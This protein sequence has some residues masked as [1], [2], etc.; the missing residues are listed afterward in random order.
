MPN[1]KPGF[2]VFRA[3]F[4]AGL[5][6]S[7][8][9]VVVDGGTSSA[10]SAGVPNSVLA[11]GSAAGVVGDTA[12][13]VGPIAAIAAPS[14]GNGYWVTSSTGQVTS[15]G[16]AVNYGSLS[17][18]LQ[19]P[20]VGMASTPDGSGYW[21]V[22]SD[23]GIFTFGD[24]GFFGS[25]GAIRLNEPIVGMA[26][27][28]DGLGY[29][30]VSSDGG[31][32]AFGDAGFL[33][34]MGGKTL[35]QPVVGMSANPNGS[36]YWLV[37][38]DGGIFSF[39]NAG[40]FGSM[41][42]TTLAQPVVGMTTSSDGAGYRM[43]ASDG[44]IFSFGDAPSYGAASGGPLDAPIVGMAPR[45]GG[46]WVAY[47]STDPL[48]TILG[49]EELLANLG[50]LPLTWTHGEF[51]WRWAPPATLAAQWAPGQNN[52]MARGAIMAFESVA[53]LPTDGAI[54]SQEMAALQ[55]ASNN[56]SS[57]ANPNGYS[58]ALA[59]ETSPETLTIWHNGQI[60]EVT[61]ANTGGPGTPTAKGTFPVYLRLR[62]QVMRGTNP[63]GTTYA[64]PVQFVAYFNGGDALHYMPRTSY[65]DPQ[66]LGCV[67]LPLTAASIV[68]PYM[69]IGSL[70]TVA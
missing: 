45:S 39:G 19:A 24:A 18:A 13:L 40:F 69:T 33:G 63:N 31:V 25:T 64:D 57:S 5:L 3:A 12:G 48:N 2:H 53:G 49:Q 29:W 42:G 34:S 38:S 47:G 59:T 46:Y 20:I 17:G 23:G 55:S 28:S 15:E 66:S 8:L 9:S 56:P 67:E 4:A 30:L 1:H 68:W 21:L 7:V 6:L 10:A 37:A 36:G 62:N 14:S 11:F 26:A 22:G 44:G 35:N 65:G 41:G 16:D 32:F 58:Y 50:Y 43:V 52:A 60:V 54:S 27:T 51:A 70:V 61:E